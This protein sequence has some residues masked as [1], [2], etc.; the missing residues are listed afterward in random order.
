MVVGDRHS[1][2]AGLAAKALP[3]DKF[4][5][6]GIVFITGSISAPGLVEALEAQTK[7][8]RCDS[9][10]LPRRFQWRSRSWYGYGRPMARRTHGATMKTSLQRLRSCHAM[11]PNQT[12]GCVKSPPEMKNRSKRTIETPSEKIK[13]IYRSFS[14]VRFFAL[15]V[16]TQ[17]RAGADCEPGIRPRCPWLQTFQPL[18]CALSLAAAQLILVRSLGEWPNN[19]PEL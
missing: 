11:P 7:E 9:S 10:A 13:T 1:F 14:C 12:R 3:P 17:P 16:F 6:I 15:G 5:P 19:T 8:G 18:L 2:W 4:E